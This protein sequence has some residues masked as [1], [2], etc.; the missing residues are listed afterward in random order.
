MCGPIV[1]SVLR[2]AVAAPLLHTVETLCYDN[3]GAGTA[4]RGLPLAAEQADLGPDTTSAAAASP[5]LGPLLHRVA[6]DGP[7]PSAAVLLGTGRAEMLI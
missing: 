3:T 6:N 2:E 1:W 5:L 4:Q 7:S